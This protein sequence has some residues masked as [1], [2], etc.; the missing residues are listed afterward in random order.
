MI[1]NA[2]YLTQY[3][4]NLF[5]PK[6]VIALITIDHQMVV[7]QVQV[8]NNFIKDVF[9][10]GGFKVNIITEKLKV[11]LG[12]SKPK[13]TPYDLHMADQTIIKP[14]GLIKDLKILVHGI[15]YAVTFILI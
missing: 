13:P 14:L 5:L 6:L 7:I 15:P 8:G 1:L 2:T 9:L 3:H 4:Q 11:K 12:L 10:D